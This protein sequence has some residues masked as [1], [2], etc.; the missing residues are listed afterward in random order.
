MVRRVRKANLETATPR[1]KLP[2]AKKPIFVP[3]GPGVSLGY[4]RNKTTGTWVLRIADGSGGAKTTAIGHADD[5][6]TA[7]DH[8]VLT[9]W[10]AQDKARLLVRSAGSEKIQPLT[11]RRAIEQYLAALEARSSAHTA[12]DTRGRLERLFLPTFA[13]GLVAAL[14]KTNLERWLASLL[15]KDPDP[16]VVRRS[17]DTANRVLTMVKA[18]LNHAVK[19]NSHRVSDDSAWRHV[20]PFQRVSRARDTHFTMEEARS[21]IRAARKTDSAFADLLTAGLLTGAR[22]GELISCRVCSFDRTHETLHIGEGKTGQRTI[23]LQSDAVKFFS[24]ITA[25]RDRNAPLLARADGHAWRSSQQTRRMAE[26][27][28]M[29]GANLESCFYTLRHTYISRSIE[30]GVPLIVLAQN[31]GTSVRMIETTYAKILAEHRR[32][33]IQAGAPTLD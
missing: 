3:I 1:L 27:V 32:S 6:E 15:R 12:K 7:D 26:V 33:Y 22:Y 5:F 23:I 2:V 21:L 16:E 30:A 18:A 20:R 17:K 14:T 10:Q 24:G 11:V 25:D 28:A 29:V 9:Y 8:S 13:D 19:D 31:C 4:R